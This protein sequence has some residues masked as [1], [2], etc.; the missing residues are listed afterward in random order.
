MSEADPNPQVKA[1]QKLIDR[2]GAK[3]KASFKD[4]ETSRNYALGIKRGKKAKEE[5]AK[6]DI[7]QSNQIFATLQAMLPLMYAKNP[8]IA[9]K[10]ESYV[11]VT[12]PMLP[13]TRQFT[14]TLE[15]VLNKVLADA[16]LKRAMMALVRSCQTSRIGWVKVSYQ[17][18]YRQDPLIAN[19]LED[20]QNTMATLGKNV[21]SLKDEKGYSSDELEVKQK[22][23]DQT[24]A[25]L[26]S[27]VSVMYSEGLVLDNI[28]VEDMRMDPDIDSLED[29]ERATWIA[30]R[31]W[32]SKDN[33]MSQF[34]LA[35]EEVDKLTSY[36]RSG[37]GRPTT[38]G[39]AKPYTTD[40]DAESLVA[41]WE[42]W[43]KLTGSVY[44]HAE[45]GTDF[46]RDPWQPAKAGQRF[47]PFFAIGFNYINGREWP[48]SDVELLTRLQDEY[49]LSRTQ[50]AK[51]R[52]STSEPHESPQR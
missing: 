30:Q 47:F 41:V 24:I 7:V 2:S 20:A 9:V 8:E 39:T 37:S 52:E 15:I 43:D 6:S 5:Y 23:L 1:I 50:E 10:P 21:Q 36:L 49:D 45:G 42:F 3:W 14:K 12:D 32:M 26:K 19:R 27:Q 25:S 22:E 33:I 17:R 48:L 51:H 31:T 11:D 38:E 13:Q 44:W 46:L 29:Y 18:D 34:G 16:G 28:L 40:T 35:K 4:I